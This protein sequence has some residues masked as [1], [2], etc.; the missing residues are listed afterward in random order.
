MADYCNITANDFLDKKLSLLTANV[1]LVLCFRYLY[2]K[3]K[4]TTMKTKLMV[5]ALLVALITGAAVAADPVGPKVVVVNQKESGMFKVIYEGVKAG[6]VNLKISNQDG[7]VVFSESVAGVNGFI[8]SVNF[9]GMNAGEYT[10]EISD[11]S[12]KQVSIVNYE[13]EQSVGPVHV[14]KIAGENKYLFAVAKGS[15]EEIN[16]K[17]FD[18]SSNLVHNEN[19]VVNG[20]FGLVYNLKDVAGTPTFEVTDKTGNTKVIKY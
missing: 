20:N 12:G 1:H 5:S 2:R 15:N 9:K 4:Q 6:R 11:A 8:R 3:Q 10:I 16:V 18:G 7:A 19:L 13:I 17:I 14:A